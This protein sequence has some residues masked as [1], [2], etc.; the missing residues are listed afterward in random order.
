MRG[1]AL[2]NYALSLGVRLTIGEGEVQIPATRSYM[3]VCIHVQVYIKILLP[4][5]EESSSHPLLVH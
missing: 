2:I 4:I 3:S 5:L 1:R